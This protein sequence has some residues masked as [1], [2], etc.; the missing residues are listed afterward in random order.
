MT[1]TVA[2]LKSWERTADAIGIGVVK[3]RYT[4][5][6]R[7][8]LEKDIAQLTSVVTRV[9]VTTG[10]RLADILQEWA[11]RHVQNTLGSY[12][13]NANVLFFSGMSNLKLAQ[14]MHEYTQNVSFADPLLQLGIPKL[15]TSLD[16]LQLYSA[17]AHHVLDWALPGVMSSD[18]M[19][20]WSRFLLRKAI[21]GATVVVAPVHDLDDFD[22]EDLA[23]KTIVTSTVSDERLARLSGQG[24]RDGGRR[25]AVPVRPRDRAQ[26]PGRHDHRGDGQATRGAPRGR[27][28]GDPHPAG[29]RAADPLPQRL[30]A[31]QPL[32]LRH[33]PALAGVLQEGQADRAAL[34]G[35]AADLHG[36]AR[37]GDGL[38]AALRLL[39]GDRHQVP[40]RRGGRGLA[41][42]RRWNAEGDHEP[43]PGVHVPPPPGRREDRQAAGRADHGPGR[44][45]EGRGRRGRHRREAAHRCRSPPA[46]ATAPPAR[47]GRRATRSCASGSSPR[48]S[49]TERSR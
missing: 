16:A 20:E 41:H 21:H 27:L 23:G 29:G 18:L 15:L 28:P 31:R 26:P 38:H 47:S 2:L 45:H 13:T 42:L 14:T 6:S 22:R 35:V 5:P 43:R 9:P 36:H 11:V 17:G 19:K 33:P 30:Q 8:Y 49:P 46:T 37:E 34:P 10:A 48:R 39:E 7:R 40:D 32:R 44:L 12:F 25:L 4:L 3:D 1:K 24:R